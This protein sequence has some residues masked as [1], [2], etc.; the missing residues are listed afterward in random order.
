MNILERNTGKFLN[1]IKLGANIE[2][3]PTIYNDMVV[4]VTRGG[5]NIWSKN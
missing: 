2:S 5:E 4:V 3:S 1:S